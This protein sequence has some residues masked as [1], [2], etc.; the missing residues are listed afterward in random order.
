MEEDSRRQDKRDEYWANLRRFCLTG[1]LPSGGVRR[2]SGAFGAAPG[3]FLEAFP[4]PTLLMDQFR[5]CLDRWRDVSGGR[6]EIVQCDEE[7]DSFMAQASATDVSGRTYVL[8]SDSDF[9][10]YGGGVKYVPLDGLG[11]SGPVVYGTVLSRADV[12]RCLGL[13]DESAVVE[14]SILLGNDFTRHHMSDR[15]R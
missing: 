11:I 14:L 3:D 13:P 15:D 6:V 9:L 12:A 4:I 10:T 2:G 5:S 8:G 1:A 7:A